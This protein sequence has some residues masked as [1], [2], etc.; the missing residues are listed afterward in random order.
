MTNEMVAI[1]DP[2]ADVKSIVLDLLNT[3]AHLRTPATIFQA[4]RRR[5]PQ[6]SSSDIRAVIKTLVDD[7]VLTYTHRFSI[8]HL[9]PNFKQFLIVSPRLA[10]LHEYHLKKEKTHLKTVVLKSGTSFGM[11]DHPTT[12]LALKSVDFAVQH[13]EKETR[14]SQTRA[15]DIGTGSGVLALSAVSL[16]IGWALAIDT[17]PMAL[18]EASEN[19]GLNQFQDR[20]DLF[21]GELETLK[22]EKFDLLMANLRPPT[23]KR[24]FPRMQHFTKKNG[25]WVIT[26]F[27]PENIDGFV[28]LV[29]NFSGSPIRQETKNNWSAMVISFKNDV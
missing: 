16:G 9:E 1:V 5:L 10:L 2:T 13:L 25:M 19:I 23:L 26:G 12:R 11:G 3:D 15:L 22:A 18:T 21:Q 17:D 27:R 4:I 6:C 20:I 29:K 7:G 14:I 28:R 24:L 8:S